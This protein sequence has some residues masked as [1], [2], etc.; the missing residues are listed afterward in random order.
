MSFYM[1]NATGVE[2]LPG[3]RNLRGSLFSIE[4]QFGALGAWRHTGEARAK[5][6]AETIGSGETEG[7]V[8]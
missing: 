5:T 7:A 2:K 1:L 8:C 6:L 3:Y 4:V